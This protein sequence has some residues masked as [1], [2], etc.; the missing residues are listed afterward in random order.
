MG[1]VRRPSQVMTDGPRSLGAAPRMYATPPTRRAAPRPASYE[2]SA[3][4]TRPGGRAGDNNF[5]FDSGRAANGVPPLAILFRLP[6]GPRGSFRRSVCRSPPRIYFL[7]KTKLINLIRH[8]SP[9]GMNRR[10]P[11]THRPTSGFSLRRVV[12]AGSFK[13]A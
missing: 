10:S 2:I 11:R 6:A 3:L 8:K 5:I 7:I 12:A 1:R 13:E 4:A 9:S